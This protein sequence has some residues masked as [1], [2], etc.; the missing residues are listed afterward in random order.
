MEV[1]TGLTI[2][3]GSVTPQK[4]YLEVD[5]NKSCYVI[6]PNGSILS[7]T[8]GYIRSGFETGV[9]YTGA[10]GSTRLVTP[11]N[12]SLVIA[13]FS[14]YIGTFRTS[15]AVE[16]KLRS[17]I[18]ITDMYAPNAT[19]AIGNGALNM[20]SFYAPMSGYVDF[21]NTKVTPKAIGDFFFAAKVNNHL[22][23]GTG[24]FTNNL[25]GTTPAA[26]ATYMGIG[27]TEQSLLDW[28]DFNLPNW[29][30]TF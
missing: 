26:V 11:R 12:T 14:S 1:I 6:L 7:S 16:V 29:T 4:V 2:G 23:A 27:T 24:R 20:I 18:N 5:S 25:V 22:Y 21:E 28:I 19:V 3:D 17:A 30:I 9:N 15:L 13:S 10:A 8:D